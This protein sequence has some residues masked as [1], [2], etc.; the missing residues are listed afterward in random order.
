MQVI[1][2][3]ALATTATLIAPRRQAA[4][5]EGREE[6]EK[7]WRYLRALGDF[8]HVTGQLYSFEAFLQKTAPTEQP[9]V[10]ACLN[11]Q[12]SLAKLALELLLRT[13]DET[14]EPEQ[15]RHVH[16]LIALLNFIADTGQ[17]ADGEDFFL[18]QLKYAPVA[19]AHFPHR[20]EAEVWLKDAKEPP[21]PARILVGDEYYQF[22]YTPE[23][24]TRGMYRDYAVEPAMEVLT[25]RG[26]PP[27]TPSF[28]TREEAEAWL[29]THPASPYAFVLIAGE[30]H[31]AVH[32]RRLKRHSLHPVASALKAWEERKRAVE[33]EQ[34]LEQE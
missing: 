24:N 10:S 15:K 30:L 11:S 9:A 27:Q 16:V 31:F 33:R 20:E 21:S 4:S 7:L 12:G 32:H 3:D 13:L 14:P 1:P 19:I 22:W 34:T 17:F 29:V 26:V 18:H 28:D 2:H 8:V 25:A 5:L 23:D 6:E